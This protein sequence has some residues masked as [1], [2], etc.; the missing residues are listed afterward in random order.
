MSYGV[1]SGRRYRRLQKMVFGE[2]PKSEPD[3]CC[4][5]VE[6]LKR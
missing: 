2:V 3:W 4:S 5:I 1:A 6:A